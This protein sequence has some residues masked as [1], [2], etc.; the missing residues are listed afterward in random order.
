MWLLWREPYVHPRGLTWQ[1]FLFVH[2]DAGW[3]WRRYVSGSLTVK[4]W[5]LYSI[6]FFGAFSRD[7]SPWRRSQG[8]CMSHR[9]RLKN[10]HCARERSRYW[11]SFTCKSFLVHG[12]SKPDKSYSPRPWPDSVLYGKSVER[13]EVS[14]I[15]FSW[16]ILAKLHAESNFLLTDS[17]TPACVQA[18][19]SERVEN[20]EDLIQTDELNSSEG[21]WKVWSKLWIRAPKPLKKAELVC[22]AKS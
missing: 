15:G 7:L 10:S 21:I 9:D 12:G 2:G 13:V 16:P 20:V 4:W 1:V 8:S 18:W 6:F 17:F 22:V 11:A 5:V 3:C 19:W 14:L